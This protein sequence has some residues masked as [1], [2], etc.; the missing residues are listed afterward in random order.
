MAFRQFLLGFLAFTI[1]I[2]AAVWFTL[3]RDDIPYSR[4]ETAYGQEN[5]IFLDLPGGL[6]G[7]V[8]DVGPRDAEHTLVLVHGLGDSV[9]TWSDW[10]HALQSDYR[11]VVIDLPGHGLTRAPY[12]Y[13]ASV[14]AAVAFVDDVAD[15]MELKDFTLVGASL[16]GMV[17]WTYTLDHPGR[18]EAL[19]LVDAKGWE[20]TDEELGS[21]PLSDAKNTQDWMRPFLERMDMTDMLINHFKAAFEDPGLVTDPMKRRISEL[22]LAPGHRRALLDYQL[23][24][25]RSASARRLE[26]ITVPTLV[27]QG[28]K[29]RIVPER[30][31]RL[32]TAAIPNAQLIIYEG[33]GHLPHR[34][35]PNR[36]ATDLKAFIASLPAQRADAQPEA[37]SIVVK[38]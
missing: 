24:P 28:E 6:L 15:A 35:V 34:E 12:T 18:V 26:T 31:A 37:A 10:I 9:S 8:I 32:F 23:S 38:R 16:G 20:L 25:H 19:V 36:S 14:D 5:S 21:D 7:H 22:S 4:L 11:L 29:D 27:M 30:C 3:K 33:A 17:A 1:V 2:A 13:R